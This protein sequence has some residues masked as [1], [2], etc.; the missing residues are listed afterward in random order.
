MVIP[1]F[2]KEFTIYAQILTKS[3]KRMTHAGSGGI[4]HLY[5]QS[6]PQLLWTTGNLS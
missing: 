1:L 2:F 3:G 5:P 6:Y 4:Q